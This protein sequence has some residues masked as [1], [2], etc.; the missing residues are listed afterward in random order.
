VTIRAA[1]NEMHSY[2]ACM[3]C[4]PHNPS[5]NHAAYLVMHTQHVIRHKSQACRGYMQL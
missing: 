1:H 3:S 2:M 5:Y 4:L